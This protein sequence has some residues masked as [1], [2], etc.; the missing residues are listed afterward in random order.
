LSYYLFWIETNFFG[1]FYFSFNCQYFRTFI[2]FWF[3]IN[4]ILCINKSLIFFQIHLLFVEL[5]MINIINIKV[6]LNFLDLTHFNTKLF[7]LINKTNFSEYSQISISY[8][9]TLNFRL[10]PINLIILILIS[11]LNRINY[12]FWINNL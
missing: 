1:E 4:L 10:M 3:K 6:T 12:S 7:F 8:C 11:R 2:N 5:K 9:C